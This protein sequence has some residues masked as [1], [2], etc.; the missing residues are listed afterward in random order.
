MGKFEAVKITADFYHMAIEEDDMRKSLERYSKY[1]GHVHIAENHRYQPGT[2]SM[3][4]KSLIGTLKNIGYDGAVVY[5]CR[6]RG[7]N[8]QKAYAESVGY[9]RRFF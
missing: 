8:P 4:F 3:D 9:M 1:I 6:V 7:E 5:E 2:G